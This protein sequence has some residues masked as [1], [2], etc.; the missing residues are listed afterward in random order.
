MA[1]KIGLVG[2]GRMGA[3]MARRLRETGHVISAVYDRDAA[4][5]AALA[6]ELQTEAA[7]TLAAVTAASDIVITVVSDDRA[8]LD[9][10]AGTGD[11]LL[12]GARGRIFINCA[13]ISPG[14]HQ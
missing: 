9:V 3:N 8:Q 12:T 5:T 7:A 13:T 6:A 1:P 14:V 10:F 11:S 2:V 4:R